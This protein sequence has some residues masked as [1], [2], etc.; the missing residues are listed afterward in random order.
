MS[1]FD[2]NKSLLKRKA[3]IKKSFKSSR[4]KH[5]RLIIFRSNKNIY[6]QLFDDIAQKT[7]F[8]SS[9][10]SKDLKEKVQSVSGKSNQSKEVGYH[11][12]TLLKKKKINKFIFDRNGYRYHGR[13]KAIA[14]GIREKGIEF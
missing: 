10:I 14:D 12:A 4:G 2:K 9:T 3:R 11:I 13:V 1:K 8:S 5:P 7:L 6:A